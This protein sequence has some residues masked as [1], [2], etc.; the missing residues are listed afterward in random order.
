MPQHPPYLLALPK[1]SL[2]AAP[3][4]RL[5]SLS[6]HVL[7]SEEPATFHHPLLTNRGR[8]AIHTSA[9][10]LSNTWLPTRRRGRILPRSSS[11]LQSAD[12]EETA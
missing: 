11:I 7:T 5:V 12:G 1:Y 6:Q 8:R 2:E 9:T 4:E 10:N 3:L